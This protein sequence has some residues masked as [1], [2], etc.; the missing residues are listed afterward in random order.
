MS[1][2]S[3]KAVFAGGCFWCT[4]AVFQRIE[5][6]ENIIPG[7]TGGNKKNPSYREVCTGSTGH[8]E[9]IE[10]TFNT[11]MVSYDTL[12]EVF[13]A[14]HDATTR[15]RQ[16]NDVGTHYRSAIFYTSEEQ[17]QLAV[18]FIQR[19]EKNHV[20]NAPIVTEIQP[21]DVFYK[22]EISHQNYYNDNSK[23]SYCEFVIAPKIEKIKE[24]YSDKL[25]KN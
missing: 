13:F 3:R 12:L 21:F 1:A 17:R 16:G 6:V 11:D 5:G 20:F 19:L 9:T 22:A 8:A 4:E 14:T 18:A 10:I 25:K 24:L 7:F 2:N 15:N 23:Q